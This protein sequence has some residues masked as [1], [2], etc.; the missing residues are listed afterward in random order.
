MWS[1]IIVSAIER[2]V[3]RQLG[4]SACFNL[5]RPHEALNPSLVGYEWVVGEGADVVI[6]VNVREPLNELLPALSG[7]L[8]SIFVG[9]SR[10]NPPGVCVYYDGGDD[11]FQAAAHLLE[12]GCS[13]I[14]FFSPHHADWAEDRLAGAR[15]AVAQAGLAPEALTV[16]MDEGPLPHGH[17]GYEH[18]QFSYEYVKR[19]I[20][21]E[22]KNLFAGRVGVIAANDKSAEGLIMA[23]E[24]HGLTP[25]NDFLI[26][27]FD[28]NAIARTLGLSSV[29]PPLEE[30][31]R[32]AA[33]LAI[34]SV[35]DHVAPM[36]CC[37][38][39]SLIAR[40]SSR[41]DGAA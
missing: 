21:S 2:E 39:S 26:I 17:P 29:R 20:A 36:S 11:G 33:R 27:G 7:N 31:G 16:R 5:W 14:V 23:T 38:H 32:E 30:L 12:Q 41:A 25:G 22:G 15:N 28:D 18:T 35:R 3:T 1:Y 10:Y 4:R 37:L 24:E 9:D 34:Q 40:G 8:Q 19:L 6:F 13:K